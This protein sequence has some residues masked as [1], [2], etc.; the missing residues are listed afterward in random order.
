MVVLV[1]CGFGVWSCPVPVPVPVVFARIVLSQITIV[2]AIL[3]DNVILAKKANNGTN[4]N[5]Q[6]KPHPDHAGSLEIAVKTNPTSTTTLTNSSAT[7][8]GVGGVD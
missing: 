3:A 1:D 2:F 7:G 6:A 8:V 4:H 5:T